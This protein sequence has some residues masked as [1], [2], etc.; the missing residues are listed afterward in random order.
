MWCFIR[1]QYFFGC[2][3]PAEN[4]GGGEE[5]VWKPHEIKRKKSVEP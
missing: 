5:C 3:L 2:M 1:R 4:T